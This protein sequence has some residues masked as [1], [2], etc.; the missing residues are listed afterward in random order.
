MRNKQCGVVGDALTQG[1]RRQTR[2]TVHNRL[3]VSV[4]AE[5]QWA[6]F[7]EKLCYHL[8]FFLSYHSLAVFV[9]SRTVQAREV[10]CDSSQ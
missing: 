5:F 9:V 4:G 3:D 7:N 2:A 6:R 8:N 1:N 10:L